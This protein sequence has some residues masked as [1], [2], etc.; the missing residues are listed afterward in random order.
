MTYKSFLAQR[1]S[2]IHTYQNGGYFI[3]LV[4][5]WRI[6][7]SVS[8]V[9]ATHL[10]VE[11]LVQAHF[12]RASLILISYFLSPLFISTFLRRRKALFGAIING[13]YITVSYCAFYRGMAFRAELMVFL[14][15]FAFGLMCG[16][17]TGSFH[18]RL[19][20]ICLRR[21]CGSRTN[22]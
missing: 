3:S 11:T 4:R 18:D 20:T 16:A 8:I 19:G 22:G 14:A 1:N 13:F 17:A 5:S 2:D 7:V 15:V 6:P 21:W 12:S 9:L 10:L